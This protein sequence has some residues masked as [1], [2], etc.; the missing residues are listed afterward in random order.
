MTCSAPREPSQRAALVA[1]LGSKACSPLPER[2]DD[3]VVQRL[4]EIGQDG[5]ASRLDERIDGHSRQ[6]LETIEARD[7]LDR[8]RDMDEV[9]GR[10]AL[11]IDDDVP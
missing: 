5:S 2:L 10:P 3:L 4:C 7:L 11:L 1:R 9:V 6:Q 8:G